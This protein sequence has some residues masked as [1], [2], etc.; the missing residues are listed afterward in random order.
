MCCTCEKIKK[1][2]IFPYYSLFPYYSRLLIKNR[3]KLKLFFHGALLKTVFMFYS[4]KCH[5]HKRL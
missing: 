5:I 1:P 3:K 4:I 2:K